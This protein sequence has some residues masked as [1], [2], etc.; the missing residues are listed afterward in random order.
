M[1]HQI[2][3]AAVSGEFNIN[4]RLRHHPQLCLGLG[5]RRRFRIGYGLGRHG[6][7]DLGHGGV[8]N[9]PSRAGRKQDRENERE[10]NK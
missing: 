1:I 7:R 2:V 8:L 5:L 4:I 3:K 9:I 6:G 10:C